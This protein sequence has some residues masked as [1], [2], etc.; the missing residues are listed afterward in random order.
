MQTTILTVKQSFK[1]IF[2]HV[3]S[4]CLLNKR[5]ADFFTGN[6]SVYSEVTLALK[7]KKK[8]IRHTDTLSFYA[9]HTSY[10]HSLQQDDK[11]YLQAVFLL[12]I[13]WQK[14]LLLR[15]SHR[16]EESKEL[17]ERICFQVIG[18]LF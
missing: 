14:A 4:F 15:N 7:K 5:L 18:N 6:L 12:P 17:F 1:D 11:K 3:R 10:R 16:W 2:I 8:L 13:T 9:L